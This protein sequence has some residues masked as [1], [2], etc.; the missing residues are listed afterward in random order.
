MYDISASAV[1]HN[2]IVE[3]TINGLLANGCV[4]AKIT[5]TYP[6]S[7]FHIADPGYAEVYIEEKIRPGEMF[8]TQALVPWTSSVSFEDETH[9]SVAIIVNN[10]KQVT[11]DVIDEP[12]QF[13]VCGIS[14]VV[15]NFSC[16]VVPE[17]SLLCRGQFRKLF[18]PASREECEAW[19]I[20]HCG[21]S[22][23]SASNVNELGN[24]SDT[25]LS[26]AEPAGSD[27]TDPTLVSELAGHPL[28][29]YKTGDAIT[30]DFRPDRVNIEIDAGG[31]IV[32]VWFG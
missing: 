19:M 12:S 9:D 6:G 14:G 32:N 23:L 20:N 3:V 4:E 15:G 8:C 16:R 2:G 26:A 27:S 22:V 11:V 24:G 13:N 28:R 7:V 29:V 30:E 21:E 25:V 18:G 17:G 31:T 5:G 1:R 10:E